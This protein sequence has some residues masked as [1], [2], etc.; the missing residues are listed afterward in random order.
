MKR[1]MELVRKLVLAMEEAPRGTYSNTLNVD[2]RTDEEIGFHVCL[3]LNEGFVEG[4]DTTELAGPVPEAIATGLTWQG[5]NFAAAAR[6]E[7]RWARV[8]NLLSNSAES[9]TLVTIS[10]LL[11]GAAARALAAAQSLNV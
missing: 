8:M 3:L 9:A 1:D 10:N 7:S 4:R 2:G 5:H 6:N 11:Q